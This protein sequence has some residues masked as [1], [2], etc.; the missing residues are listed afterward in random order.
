MADRWVKKKINRES[1]CLS[2]THSNSFSFYHLIFSII[3]LFEEKG[4]VLLLSLNNSYSFF[5]IKLSVSS[6]KRDNYIVK[7]SENT[8][9]LQRFYHLS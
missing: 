4:T 3:F 1:F 8:L 6:K 9:S 5:V 2:I 7:G